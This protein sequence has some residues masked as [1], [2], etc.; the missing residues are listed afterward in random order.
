MPRDPAAIARDAEVAFVGR[1][2]SRVP[3]DYA[4]SPRCPS[5]SNGGRGLPCGG[6]IATL[7]VLTP[8]RGAVAGRV[9]VLAGDGCLCLGSYLEP[10]ERYLVVAT[11]NTKGFGADLLAEDVCR[12]TMEAAAPEAAAIIDLLRRSP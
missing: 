5:I 8:L 1:V 12:G 7:E 9:T 4:R 2:V 6:K 3:A 10:G 11:V